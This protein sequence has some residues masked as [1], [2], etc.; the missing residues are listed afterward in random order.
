MILNAMKCPFFLIYSY[1]VGRR[2]KGPKT[3]LIVSFFANIWM[4][5]NHLGPKY[6][7]D[8]LISWNNV[9]FDPKRGL[10]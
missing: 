1:G 7:M 4:T 5:Y 2:L 10:F 3:C 9:I 6:L 8:L